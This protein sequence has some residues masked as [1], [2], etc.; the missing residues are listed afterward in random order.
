[1]FGSN[2]R[3]PEYVSQEESLVSTAG[4]QRGGGGRGRGKG[5]REKR[6]GGGGRRNIEGREKEYWGILGG[7]ENIE[8]RRR[9]D[10]EGRMNIERGLEGN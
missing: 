2:E 1:M 6:V 9:E 7:R 4:I 5:G 10:G 8:E 3:G